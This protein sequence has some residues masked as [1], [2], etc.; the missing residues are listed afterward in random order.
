LSFSFRNSDLQVNWFCL[1]HL[2][3]SICQPATGQVGQNH[4][5]RIDST[6]SLFYVQGI[7]SFSFALDKQYFFSLVLARN[8]I[9]SHCNSA[10]KKCCVL[11]A[12]SYLY[13]GKY[14]KWEYLVVPTTT[15][16]YKGTYQHTIHTMYDV[17]M[18]SIILS[19]ESRGVVFVTLRGD[20][21]STSAAPPLYTTRRHRYYMI[22]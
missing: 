8:S 18:V 20:T 12:T 16:Y 9:S 1:L 17:S 4:S 13:H 21:K 15:Y 3:R 10:R 11:I 14:G 6:P 2:Q 19:I 22:A 5:N 7:L